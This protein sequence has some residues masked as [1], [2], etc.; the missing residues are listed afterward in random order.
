M[1][2]TKQKM[3]LLLLTV[4]PTLVSTATIAALSQ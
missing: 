2:K 4:A 1:T 3:F